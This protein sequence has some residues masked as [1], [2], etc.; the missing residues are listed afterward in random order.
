[1]RK[2]APDLRQTFVNLDPLITASQTGLPALR[3]TLSGITPLLANLDPFL[4]QLNPLLQ[5][6]E[7]YQHQT[8]DFI[9][10]G[11]GAI[12]AISGGQAP[13]TVGH[14]LRQLGPLGA[15]SLAAYPTRLPSNRGNSYLPPIF[16]Q[17]PQQVQHAIFP[18]FDC[19]PSG[20]EV[21]P[22]DSQV[23]G[24]ARPGC[25]VAAPGG[26]NP[27]YS[28]GGQFAHVPSANYNP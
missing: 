4:Q 18:N 15:E 17:L 26:G 21:T 19:R 9:S 27:T 22:Q 8:A 16:S 5:W 25:I 28:K 6:L 24:Q 12:A 23:P 1:M 10:N 3:D 2:L 11:A 13:G 20:G 7:Y 14:Y